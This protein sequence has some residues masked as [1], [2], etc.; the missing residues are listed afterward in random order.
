L[1]SLPNQRC[2]ALQCLILQPEV[3]AQ[4]RTIG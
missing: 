2:D 4:I 3:A 1:P